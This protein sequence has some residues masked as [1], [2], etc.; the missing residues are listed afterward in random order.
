M[1][2]ARN[3][4]DGVYQLNN[5]VNYSCY[6][7]YQSRGNSEATCKL[8]KRQQLAWVW[9]AE[10]FRC[11]PKSCGDP[12]GIENGK[13]HGDSFIIASSVLY[14]CDEGFEMMGQA[15]RYCQSDNQWSGQPPQC[16]PVTCNPTDHLENGK[17]NYGSPLTFNSTVEYS[18]DPGFRLVGPSRRVCGPERKLTGEVP[19]CEEIDC[20]ELG[21]LHNGY[22]RGFSTRM[23]D[24]KEFACRE[25]MQFVGNS[26]ESLCLESGQWSH[27][28]PRCLAPCSV[29]RVQYAEKLYII[30]PDMIEHGLKG[31]EIILHPAEVGSFVDHESSMEIVCQEKY[32]F[33]KMMDGRYIIQ[34]P[35]CNNSTWTY[36]PR[37][38]PASCLNRPPVPPNGR[39]RLASIEHGSRGFIYCLDGYRL[40]GSNTT[41]CHRGEWSPVD[42]SC[43]EIYCSFP[44]YIEHGR[45][46]LVGLTGMYDYK[47]YIKRISNNR[48]IAFEC[49]SGYRLND[50]APGGATCID[51]QWKPEGL[52]NCIKE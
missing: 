2:H 49:D 32:E 22:I 26:T 1:N 23:G 9:T 40:K 35:R 34:A 17:I 11:I 4:S 46:L 38:K 36:E 52:P 10:P 48:Q 51:G 25:G 24:R 42:S 6:P 14:T 21:P 29:P 30:K 44:G 28:L 3:P 16:V 50:G 12:G 20:G 47:P 8:I 31:K 19:I 43:V 27:A 45:V 18:C 37:C 5:T 13:R 33:E 7:G 41:R 15:R 39:I